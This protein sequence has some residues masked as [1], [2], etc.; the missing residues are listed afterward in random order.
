MAAKKKKTEVE[1]TGDKSSS[2]LNAFLKNNPKDHYNFVENVDYKVSFGSL[3]LDIELGGIGPG[4]HRFCG[5]KE[6]GKTS[7]SLEV[8]K[9]FLEEPNRRAI[10]LKCEG[11]LSK[12]MERRSGVKF[13]YGDPT[14]DWVDGTCYV[15]ESNKFESCLT[16]ISDMVHNNLD[17]K[18]YLFII[19]SVDAM[20]RAGDV[21]KGYGDSHMVAGGA[22]LLS[23]F[24]KHMGLPVGKHGHMVIMMSQK[25]IDIPASKR[26]A[27]RAEKYSGGN[28][29]M[30][31]ADL[32]LEFLHRGTTYGDEYYMEGAS[33]VA[34]ASN[35]V[36]GH[37]CKVKVE[38]CAN[39]KSQLVL[40]Y[41]IRYGRQ[42]GRS[43]WIEKEIFDVLLSFEMVICKGAWF[44]F[45]ATVIE[46][47]AK[48]GIELPSEQIQGRAKIE[49]LVIEREEVCSYF[50]NKFK[51]NLRKDI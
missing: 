25:R 2:Q 22:V 16:M 43:I 42:G 34:D 12:E 5:I 1:E 49:R 36:I 17:K 48:A 26:S 31:Q 6:G 7:E 45:D 9:N 46:E 28:A 3:K 33:G 37:N 23:H 50:F 11:R 47:A 30:H 13:I 38:K 35:R 44:R 24:F 29:A 32:I 19:D 15:H 8:A 51:D 4:I 14:E 18:Q 40:S 21:D 10:Y 41:P 20:I 27:P 39:E